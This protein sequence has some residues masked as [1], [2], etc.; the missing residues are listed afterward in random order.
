[1]RFTEQQEKEIKALLRARQN[2][3]DDI[4]VAGTCGW[5]AEASNLSEE[6]AINTMHIFQFIEEVV[7]ELY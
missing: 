7:G 4:N 2:I 6:L 5:E 3:E 1:M